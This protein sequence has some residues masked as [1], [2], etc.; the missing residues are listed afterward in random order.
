MVASFFILAFLERFI[1]LRIELY[2]LVSSL[3]ER[4]RINRENG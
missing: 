1:R 3:I 2:N 4:S